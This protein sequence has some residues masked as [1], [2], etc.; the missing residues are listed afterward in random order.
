MGRDG[1]QVSVNAATGN[2]LISRQDEFLVGLGV[3]ASVGRTYNSLG[4]LSDDNA[5]N[6]RQSTQRRIVNLTGTLNTTG[7][8]VQR[9]GGDGAVITYTYNGTAYVATDGAGAY[10][11]LTNSGGVWTWT[12]GDTQL[13]ETYSLEYN[14]STAW[15]ITSQSDTDGNT[16]SFTYIANSNQL[17]RVTTQDG[18]YVQYDWSGP[19]I[20]DIVTGYTDLATST[21]KTLTR[22][23]YTYDAQN[24]LS[25]VTVDLSP[26]DNSI[27]DGKVYSTTYTYVGTST[28]VA[29][30]SE[31][32]GSRIDVTY[33]ASNRVQSIAE[34]VSTGV[35]RTSTL[36]YGAGYTTVTDPL[37]Q[38]VRLDYDSS[39]NLTKITM[40]AAS[41]GASPQVTQFA[42]DASGNVTS[43]TDALGNATTYANFLNGLATTVTDRLGNI[44]TRT[45][46]S[47]N[48]LLTE[49][50]TGTDAASAS[51]S[52]TARYAYDAED[53]L[54][55]KVSAE[56]F[57]CQYNYDASGNLT[58]K[59]EFPE[60]LY[61]VT[62]LQSTDAIS[63]AQLDSWVAGIADKSSVQRTDNSY[64]ARG[65]LISS[66]DYSLTTT[67]GAGTTT[68]GTTVTSVTYDQ[69]GKLLS[70]HVGS[71]NTESFV[72]DGLGRL[73]S[74]VDVNGGTTSYVFDDANTKTIVTLAT[75]RIQTSTYNKAGEL[76]DF[77]E[78]MSTT[79][80]YSEL[81]TNGDGSSA[82]GW[83]GW[84]G[85]V[86]SVGGHLRVT[87]NNTGGT[88][89]GYQVI[90]TVP[91][92]TYRISWTG[93][94][95]SG[96]AQ[97]YIGAGLGQSNLYNGGQVLSGSDTRSATFVATGTTAYVHLSVGGFTT[98][99]AEFD[100]ISVTATPVGTAT[101]GYDQLGRLRWE[102][103]ATGK[104]SYHLYDN[105]GRKTAD[106]S[107]AGEMVEYKYDADNRVIA[108]VNY[109]TVLTSAQLTS[110]DNQNAAA[111]IASFRPAS[112]SGDLWNWRVYDKEGR[113]AQTIAGDGSS[114]INT[115]DA[116][117]KL[118]ST[119]DY[120]TKFPASVL[121]GFQSNPPSSVQTSWS[122]Y[123][124]PPPPPTPSANLLPD[125][126]NSAQWTESNGLTQTSTTAIAGQPAWLYQTGPTAGHLQIQGGSVAVADGDTLSW[127]VTLM[128]TSA[129][130]STHT[131]QI[132]TVQSP[133]NNNGVGGAVV[134]S[135]PGTLALD[136]STNRWTITGLSTTQATTVTL[137]HTFNKAGGAPDTTDAYLDIGMGQTST[138]GDALIV[139]NPIVT[140]CGDVD[141]ANLPPST[142]LLPDLSNSSQWAGTNVTQTQ[143]SDI[144][145][146][147]AWKY[148]AVASNIAA[149]I[150]GHA[151]VQAGDTLSW[152][153]TL[154]SVTGVRDLM[155]ALSQDGGTTGLGN[156][157]VVSG[158]G[159]LQMNALGY[160]DLS[161]YSTLQPTTVQITHTF[162]TAGTIDLRVSYDQAVNQVNAGDAVILSNPIV[163]NTS[164]VVGSTTVYQLASATKDAVTQQFYDK[165]G[166]LIGVLDAEAFLT[167]YLYDKRGQ[168]TD[169]IAYADAA[170]VTSGTFNQILASVTADSA[171]DRHTRY[172]Y[173]GQGQL[174]F[175]V[176][177]KNQV[178]ETKFDNNGQ[179]TSVTRYANALASTTSDFTYDNVKALVAATGFASASTDRTTWSVY[180]A[181][182]RVA[183]AISGEGGVTKFAY[184][185]SGQVT[186]STQYFTTRSTTSLPTQAT[187]DSWATTNGGNAN[188]R[189]SRYYYDGAG[190]LRYVVDGEGYVTRR[191]E[192]AEGRLTAIERFANALTLTD[193]DTISSVHSAVLA[194]AGTAV[195]TSTAYD[196]DGRIQTTT[197]GEGGVIRYV[198]SANGTLQQ[199]TV[200]DAT[201]DASTTYY[202]YD[203]AGRVLQEQSAYGTADLSI[204]TYTYDGLGNVLKITDGDNNVTTQTFDQ[205]GHVL[206]TKDAKNG[207]TSFVYNAFGEVVQTTDPNGGVSYNYYDAL[208]RVTTSCDALK[209]V[210]ETSYTP[211]G[212]VASV[213]RRYNAATN[214]P[215]V[216][217]LPTYTVNAS[218]D[219]TT[220]FTY[221]RLGRLTKATDALSNYEQYTLNA[222]G[223]RISVR[224][225]L[226]GTITNTY[227]RR[228]LLLSETLPMASVNNAGTQVAA[229]V[230]NTFSYDSRGNRTKMI[231]AS[232]LAEQRTTNYTYDKADRLVSKYGDAVTKVAYNDFTSTTAVTVT[233]TTNVVP[234][235]SY[236]YDKR[237]NLIQLIDA[238]GAK[239]F[240]YYDDLN[241][242]IAEVNPLGTL[243]N[244]TYDDA[245]NRLSEKVFG[246]FVTLPA[247][248]GGTAPSPVN[249]SNYRLTSYAYD[250]LNRLTTT[251]IASVLVGTW[252]AVNNGVSRSTVTVSSTLT[253]DANGN[254]I[255]STDANG[256]ITYSWYDG[257]NRKTDQLD[258]EGYLTH[259]T[260][261]DEG[262]VLSERRYAT[263]WTGAVSTSAPP[264][265]ATAGSDRVTNFTYDRNGHRLTE[266][267]T[268]VTAWTVNSSNGALTAASTSSVV[269]YTYNALDQVTSKQEAT[270]D[271]VTYT[272]DNTG[273]LTKESRAAYVD[274]TGATVTPEVIYSYDGLNNL[275]RTQQGDK[276]AIE[277]N[278]TVGRITTYAY[279]AGGRLASMTDAAGGTHS[280]D[281]DA[282]G[283]QVRDSYT[284]TKS[285]GTTVNEGILYRRD[286]LGRIVTQTV[287]TK[288]STT[289]WTRGD[290]QNT[291]YDAYGEVSQRGVNGL[292]QETFTYNNRGL[293]EKSNT[294]DGVWRFHVYDKAGNEVLTIEDENY[295]AQDLS[296]KSLTDVLGYI[297]TY[298]G[299]ALVSGLN[300]TISLYNG[301]NQVT[302][303]RQQQRETS[304]Q[305]TPL[306][307]IVSSQTY[308]AFGEVATQT[309]ALNNVTTLTYNTM[310]RLISKVMPQ[311]SVTSATGTVSNATPTETYY[312][313]LAGRQVATK[314]ADGNTISHTILAGT[315]YGGSDAEML[316]EFHPDAG[317]KQVQYDVF[318]DARTLTDELS[319]NETRTYDGMGRLLTDAHASGLTDNYTYDLL[320]QRI[321]HWNSVLGSTVKETTDY[322]VQGRVTS[323]KDFA[324]DVTNTSYSW[325]STLATALGTNGGWTKTTTMWAQLGASAKSKSETTDVHGLTTSESDLGANA[326]TY[327]YD[328]AG[329]LISKVGSAGGIT[330][331]LAYTYF[332]TGNVATIGDSSSGLAADG[333]GFNSITSTFAYDVLGHRTR[334]TYVGTINKSVSD[335]SWSSVTSTANQTLE[336]ATIT[337]DALGRLATFSSAG[338]NGTTTVNQYY[339]AA[340]NI[341]HTATTYP[342]IVSGGTTSTDKWFT[343]DSMNRMVIANGT[344]SGSTITGGTSITYDAAGNRKTATTGGVLETYNYDNDNQ[345][346][347]VVRGGVTIASTTRNTLGQVTEYI[348]YGGGTGGLSNHRFNIV[349]NARGQVTSE[350]DYQFIS[351]GT[352]LNASVSNVYDSYGNITST[353]SVNSGT[354]DTG[355]TWNY[356][357]RDT[358]VVADTHYDSD[359]NNSSNNIWDTW[360]YYDGLDR[361]QRAKIDDARDRDV[362][363]ALDSDGKVLSRVVNDGSYS[364]TDGVN[365][366][367][368]EYHLYAG[369]VQIADYTSDENNE[370]QDY[371]YQSLINTK[372]VPTASGTGKFYRGSS[373]GVS[374]GEFGTS[375]Y[376]PVNPITA[377][378]G[379]NSRSSYTV[380]AG[381]T[382]QGIA[383]FVWGDSSLWYIIAN[384]NGLPV[385][386]PLTAGQ[387][388]ALPLKGP[389]NSNNANMFRPYD[390]ASAVGDL[391]PTMAKPPKG[392]KCG[393]FGQILLVAIAVAV[394]AA[395]T[396]P[397]S[398]AIGAALV[399]SGGTVAA[400]S[401]AAIA[402]GIAGG[403]LA[404]AAG[405][406]VSQGVGLATGMQQGFSWKGVALSALSG[407]AGGGIGE[408]GKLGNAAAQTAL[409][410]GQSLTAFGKF[411]TF[412]G[413][414][415]VLSGVA[416]GV[417]TSA[418]SQGVGVV[419]GIQDKFDWA[420]VAAAGVSG[421][422]TSA[423]GVEPISSTNR[424]IGAYLS[425][426]GASVA[427]DIANAATRSVINGSDFGD[428]LLAALPDV[429]GQ[430]IGG[431]I[432]NGISRPSIPKPD[433]SAP[434]P[435]DL[436]VAPLDHIDEGDWDAVLSGLP[437]MS[438]DSD[439][440]GWL[441]GA[442]TLAEAFPGGATLQLASYSDGQDLFSD[443]KQ[444]FTFPGIVDSLAK[445]LQELTNDAKKQSATLGAELT[446]FTWTT[447]ATSSPFTTPLAARLLAQ[448]RD[449]TSP[450]NSPDKAEFF[451][452]DSEGT[453]ELFFGDSGDYYRSV[454]N[455]GIQQM[456]S[457]G[458]GV[459]RDGVSMRVTGIPKFGANDGLNGLQDGINTGDVIGTFSYGVTMESRGGYIYFTGKNA[460]SLESFSGQNRLQHNLIINPET[461]R[462]SNT[463]QTFQWRV[464]TPPNLLPRRQ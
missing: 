65:N 279:G 111:D 341:R 316:K 259:W 178:I 67:A 145:G 299:S 4:D 413:G 361:N 336:D 290:S 385:D 364:T 68:D 184:N 198:Y 365:N 181:A 406:I 340:S 322:D 134:T 202:T 294:G 267:R 129:S 306:S 291:Q 18:S 399:G 288:N 244:W 116:E 362:H 383:Q 246:D 17:S 175:A 177:A 194:S 216:T 331:T 208:G 441:D 338:P 76:V 253:Y 218:K 98:E 3:G 88:G 42:Y 78:S 393:A 301:R 455:L 222:F 58:S 164:G 204:T 260:Y 15:R 128:A 192:D 170:S 31:S 296:T 25:T 248:P 120:S 359:Y 20:S 104:K 227:D 105:A 13:K 376:D 358:A 262:N 297:G 317:V 256:E 377:G 326:T 368:V 313:D 452:W 458:H 142:N 107:A 254:V 271:T 438:T 356:A 36:T 321:T 28:L 62:A 193:S 428:N 414:S 9:V 220:S 53:H 80:G 255:T 86:S 286:L 404:G 380:Q 375:G 276:T 209:Y 234:T 330:T 90:S 387:N 232:G 201:A 24:R 384:A 339:D 57:V 163:T 419:T 54:R 130:Q 415:G 52:H 242:K 423:L 437:Q 378:V 432:T 311:V 366:D 10:D 335:T 333:Y 21:A 278:A 121:T 449:G 355:Q 444:R 238:N 64:D 463:Y 23:R 47:K 283:S 427:S 156:M 5:D 96:Y 461:G 137:T 460:M 136:P 133:W 285:D 357:W 251:S 94:A 292:W 93:F 434:V 344:L 348:E 61:D 416:R 261:D 373:Y 27:A 424:S 162:A 447:A 153:I 280:Y 11:T 421:G 152:T 350:S 101:Y 186:K 440:A 75:G 219:A 56:G 126:S 46:G 239:T 168:K 180:D 268:G 51:G 351:G 345:L 148:T 79:A 400:G 395:L 390:S 303:V 302:Q 151:T 217:V 131:L 213:T 199:K 29:S 425:N 347:T 221:D 135:G 108:T 241:R 81:V 388:L 407:A 386:A 189:I 300:T 257:L 265:V 200:A 205:L 37:G 459:I 349:Y 144:N 332:N 228:G 329:R 158:P 431:I 113:L 2:L 233:T 160:W 346:T 122:V 87:A 16:L 411:A 95:G 41:S 35:T 382:L 43:V 289:S 249:S 124:P 109:A 281:Y 430:T 417:A 401:A 446:A 462:F 420:G 39:N 69:A 157:T 210:T 139:S 231:E 315:G 435:V 187:M 433:L 6:W 33:D 394:T 195:A 190:M 381:D 371:D 171:N 147:P 318:G 150:D 179:A 287:A 169:E 45:Y 243:T 22:T 206:T 97:L 207:V 99:Y 84:F 127:T 229:T 252:D 245:G 448:W 197:D 82:S 8:T 165:D 397:L 372:T 389:S 230:T 85:N 172:V 319:R 223:D 30:I 426:A 352:D 264:A 409:K 123:T 379:Q 328:K 293:V 360:Q 398:G 445:G 59:L 343:Y 83:T 275:S 408:L 454:T 269:T 412:V 70:R 112:A 298:A 167:R 274:Q 429:I 370:T 436:D 277:A 258:A 263:Q 273:R 173:N 185:S 456:A 310:G 55:Y 50:T 146:Q 141:P 14:S 353:H 422:I 324:A 154:Q 191:T 410:T 115:Y 183:Y 110:L 402:G 308:N 174:R 118:I 236:V 182:G 91:G 323:T 1:E 442:N 354:P 166:R 363:F 66:T 226:G 392:N 312:Y 418:I 77:T 225:K 235:E 304:G 44:T 270:G 12:D 337:Y 224:N 114:S 320:G 143:S 89:T 211:F 63:E 32:D 240:S 453:H 284:R 374:G 119:R 40:P 325:S 7:S 48:E 464:P 334:E 132:S 451:G 72:Y 450:Y 369:G 272:Y 74:A 60:Q 237:G 26:G 92:Q 138:S 100:N 159:S 342:N 403:A 106:V 443:I 307:S 71:N 212:E 149:I 266:T 367:P 214:A 19:N 396:G 247:S 309:D 391:S 103:D 327:T 439:L 49:T 38:L 161:N 457:A 295:A 176:D 117:G 305:N 188:D 215:S 140:T 155:F 203:G 250:A 73:T 282:A 405:S 125:L 34:T 102:V 314:D 196:V